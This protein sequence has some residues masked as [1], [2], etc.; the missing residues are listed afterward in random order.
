MSVYEDIKENVSMPELLERYG[1]EVKHGFAVCPFHNERTA[2]MKV[3]PDGFYCFGCGAGGD[4][5]S[6]AAKMEELGNAQAAL[7]LASEF[8]LSPSTQ[9]LPVRRALQQKKLEE[10]R[11]REL[12]QKAYDEKCNEYKA[13]QRYLPTATGEERAAVLAKMEYLEYWFEVTPW[14]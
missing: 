4:V 2:S 8:G 13:L 14:K 12:A 5:I 10:K 11:R 1:I 9:A 7:R 3:Y 6:F